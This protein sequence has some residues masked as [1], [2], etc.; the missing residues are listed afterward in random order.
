MAYDLGAKDIRTKQLGDISRPIGTPFG[1]REKLTDRIRSILKAYPRDV[2]ILK[3]LVQNADDAG[4]SEIHFV[5]DN[6]YHKTERM[7]S[8]TWHEIQGPALCVY[9]NRPFSE[10]DFEGIQ[11]LGIGSKVDDPTKTGQYGIGFNAIYHVTDC[12]SFISNGDTLCIL[13]PQVRYAPYASSHNP[14]RLIPLDEDIRAD[15]SDSL[16][17][18]LEEFFDLS[19]ATM[20][21]LPIR[22]ETMAVNSEIS[23]KQISEKDIQNLML[24]FTVE[25]KEILLFLNH[26]RKVSLSKIQNGELLPIF[27]VSTELSDDDTEKRKD[28]STNVKVAASLNTCDVSPFSITYSMKIKEPLKEESWLVHQ[29]IG[30]EGDEKENLPNGKPFGLIPRAGAAAKINEDSSA[31]SYRYG[32]TPKP[33]YKAFC[34]LPLPVYTGLPIHVNGHFY[35]DSGRRH[36]WHDEGDEGFGSNWNHFLK[37]RLLPQAYVALMENAK[38]YIPGQ[39]SNGFFATFHSLDFGLN[40][41]N[42]IFPP[43]ESVESQWKEL[44]TSF[45]QLVSIQNHN[46]FPVQ[47]MSES[48]SPPH[49]CEWLSTSQGFFNNLS[50]EEQDIDL[51]KVI[52]CVGFPLFHSPHHLFKNFTKS[53]AHAKQLSPDAVINFLKSHGVAEGR[54]KIGKLPCQLK[55][56]TIASTKK[57]MNLT[58]YCMKSPKFVQQMEG[59]P[60]LL[61]LDNVLRSFTA[62]YTVYLSS[63]HD[64]VPS[65][66][67]LFVHNRLRG[68]LGASISSES[69]VNSNIGV[70]EFN[71]TSLASFL[72][73]IV[74]CHWQGID[75]FVKWEPGENGTPTIKWMERLWEFLCVDTKSS[76][77]LLDPLGPWPLLPTS[78]GQLVP[79]ALA[80]KVLDLSPSDSWS[81]QQYMVVTILRKL[82][83]QEVNR[84]IVKETRV[85]KSYVAV[86]H[87]PEDVI[88][89][90][91]HQVKEH[92]VSGLLNK[93]E[94]IYLLEFFQS[95]IESLNGLQKA[96]IKRL[97]F[98]TSTGGDAVSID[99]AQAV[100]VVP[101]GIPQ[102]ESEVWM[103]ATDSI[104]LAPCGR[105]EELYTNLGVK[106]QS[107]V[108]CYVNFIF[109]HFST[110]CAETRLSHLEY[111]KNVVLYRLDENDERIIVAALKTLSFIPDASGKLHKASNFYDPENPVFKIMLKDNMFPST[112]FRESMWLSFLRKLD[113]KE[114]VNKNQFLAFAKKIAE[115]AALE[116]TKK[117]IQ[118]SETLV[119]Y[120]LDQPSLHDQNFLESISII[121]FVTPQKA[122]DSLQALHPQYRSTGNNRIKFGEFN[123]AVPSDHERLVWTSATLL[124][125]W[126]VNEAPSHVPESLGVLKEPL[127][128]QVLEHTEILSKTLTKSTDK[129]LPSLKRRELR[130]VMD[131]IYRFCKDKIDCSD[132]QVIGDDC[133]A[134]CK[135]IGA[136]LSSVPCVLVDDGRI[137]VRGG[138]LALE[139][140]EEFPPHLYKVPTIYGAY[141]HLF[142][143]LGA[144]SNPTPLQYA[145]ILRRLKND[146]KEEKMHP[147]EMRQAK[148]AAGGLFNTLKM[149]DDVRTKFKQAKNKQDDKH[150]ILEGKIDDLDVLFLP[151]KD[152]KLMRSCDMVSN[153]V[154]RFRHR[155]SQLQCHFLID[156]V[157]CGVN[158]FVEKNKLL[159]KQLRTKSIRSMVEEKIVPDCQ[160]K[161]CPDDKEGRCEELNRLRAILKSQEFVQGILRIL[162]HQ[163]KTS[164]L[165]LEVKQKVDE[166]PKKI[167][168]RCMEMLKTHLVLKET[169]EPIPKS[170]GNV[171]FFTA[172]GDNERYVHK[173]HDAQPVLFA[174]DLCWEI[175]SIIGNLLNYENRQNLM[176]CLTC[177]APSAISEVLDNANVTLDCEE[178]AKQSSSETELGKEVSLELH[179][180]FVQFAD[181]IFYPGEIVVYEKDDAED[182]QSDPTYIFARVVRRVETHKKTE[183]EKK[184]ERKKG[185]SKVQGKQ[186]SILLSRYL[187]DIGDEQIEVDVLDL[188]KIRRQGIEDDDDE[189]EKSS[190]ATG[191][192]MSDSKALVLYKGTGRARSKQ[193][194]ESPKTNPKPRTVQEALKEVRK[195][196]AEIKKLPKDK[197]KK[198]IRRL[199]LRW[200]PDKN[201]PDMQEIANEVSKFIQSE[202]TK[203]ESGAAAEPGFDGRSYR[204][205]DFDFENFFRQWNH[206]ARRQRSSYDNFRRSNP[207]FE[208]RF[209]SRFSGGASN[210]GFS[211]YVLCML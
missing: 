79:I 117:L 19:Q 177:E 83:C 184:K 34:F 85:L 107:Q 153:D 110:L 145:N 189:Q 75:A 105:L 103:N 23:N 2:G 187:I 37:S 59:L 173:Y 111:I 165:A 44:S 154:T 159:P 196:F 50:S 14:G 148:Q 174:K 139:T 104:F 70:R 64:L 97:P 128:E 114:A 199:Y 115:D 116:T 200:H 22:D 93:D 3:E 38:S 102:E 77:R 149:Q 203:L 11:R 108:S 1:Q 195:A 7:F 17:G 54:C 190:E 131:D 96:A 39:D 67:H 129:E 31:G 36:L 193:S 87:K 84:E 146:C 178:H 141:L 172:G 65:C 43:V 89:V 197:Q 176:I 157:G 162:K 95:D 186:E 179:Q 137:L 160:N 167:R 55:E 163:E 29:R 164:K 33:K 76:E 78:S 183:K 66:P 48:Q 180:L 16:T 82:S 24:L 127:I 151:S 58:T 209:R 21:R 28:F 41:Y 166:L 121:K 40:W 123:K 73:H 140:Q 168:L 135:A 120:L 208:A 134:S 132:S 147:E 152:E 106:V 201:P 5:Y 32:F 124:P 20:F 100:Y 158:H 90:L 205:P 88:A 161:L 57:F 113:L 61:T 60:L 133:A 47:A 171:Q 202:A 53:D 142:R 69:I 52:I 80:K 92:T 192:T 204:H 156:L 49:S 194:K 150:E 125:P 27:S 94:R 170:D 35:L 45:Y 136:R 30:L 175:N 81:P 91:E 42:S 188:Y 181:F 72:S 12:P 99:H 191:G 144:M 138:Q 18:Y 182:S 98:F 51:A 68:I 13:D 46:F 9:N 15:Y 118:K 63:F 112:P 109:P 206:R 169:D 155:V 198:A 8:K 74:P 119:R 25:A 6:R 62:E 143:R 211:R 56:T 130:K 207:N 126:I 101:P 185:K 71:V 4:A 86:P 26:V 10:D 210:S 122:N